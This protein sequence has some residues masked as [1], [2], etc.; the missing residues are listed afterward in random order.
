MDWKD[1]VI[2]LFRIASF[3]ILLIA[4]GIGALIG[5]YFGG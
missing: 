5:K 1:A 3:V 2:W 4:V